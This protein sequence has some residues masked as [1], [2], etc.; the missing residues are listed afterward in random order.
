ME[1][2]DTD[3]KLINSSKEEKNK[4]AITCTQYLLITCFSLISLCALYCLFKQVKTTPDVP[5]TPTFD[6]SNKIKT[7]SY[8]NIFIFR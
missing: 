2:F 5:A 1:E 3:E 4:S 7:I 6:I 8:F